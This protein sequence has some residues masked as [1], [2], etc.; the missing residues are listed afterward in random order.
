MNRIDKSFRK[1]ISQGIG[2]AL[3][4]PKNAYRANAFLIISLVCVLLF[5]TAPIS[6]AKIEAASQGNIYTDDLSPGWQDWSWA[7]TDLQ[8]TG[9]VHSGSYSISVNAN[10]WGGVQLHYPGYSTNGFTS[11]QFYINGGTTGGQHLNLFAT[12]MVNGADQQSTIISLPLLIA[13]TWN[14]ISVSLSELGISNTYLTT[15]VWQNATANTLPIYYLDDIAL[16]SDEDP[17][18]PVLTSPFLNPRAVP[19]DGLTEAVVRI[20]VA[21]PQGLADIASVTL[22]GSALGR[23]PIELYDDGLSNDGAANDGIF[24]AVFSVAPGTASAEAALVITATDQANHSSSLP[25]GAFDIL[26]SFSGTIPSSLPS[27]LGWGSN[28]WSENPGADWQQN[29]GVPWNYDYQYI[30]YDW[31]VNGWGG[32]F[33]TRFVNQAWSKNYVPLISVYLILGLPPTC[34]ESGACYATKLQDPI[35]VYRYLS[36]IQEAARQAQGEKPV[37]FQLE[38]DFYGYMQQLSNQ[39]DRPPGVKPDDPSSY[40]VALN[41]SG[42]PNNLAGFGR[43][44]V[45]VIHATAPNALVAPHASMW[46]TNTDPFSVV[47]SEVISIAQ[48]TAAFIDAMGGAQSNL[49]LVEWS[50]RDAGSGL[51]PWWDDT[52]QSLPRPA[53][54][55]LWENALSAAANKRL[56]LWQVPVGNMALDNTCEQ[57]QD[58]KAAYLFHHPRDLFDAGVFAILFGGGAGCSTQVWTDG[59]YVAAQGAIAYELPSAPTGLEAVASTGPLILVHWNENTEPDIFGYRIDFQSTLGG[60]HYYVDARRKNSENVL[61]P[62]KGDW[63]IT[64]AAYD[65]MHQLGPDA[66]PVF[67]H[68]TVDASVSLLP[69]IKR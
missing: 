51:R 27:T 61:L 47:S 8:A 24:G 56:I 37:I 3:K 44:V 54:A 62:Q 36:A 34:G 28:A 6:Y 43:R 57:Y 32:N 41:I 65:A 45:D 69:F 63:K 68:T 53:R 49:V 16:I 31:Y 60:L 19:A 38:P 18:G 39:A 5:T 14:K 21:D 42:Y 9:V 29:S 23:G 58:N 22:D 20:Q 17:D 30:T 59:G 40:P 64:V 25:I 26:S 11:L 13:N 48:R 67:V 46:A 52:N 15:L 66:T 55:V 33:V 1:I 35:A 50:D 10:A 4:I 12:Y 7:Q 2:N